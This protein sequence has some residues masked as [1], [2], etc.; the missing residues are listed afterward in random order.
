MIELN[1][2]RKKQRG[3]WRVAAIKKA[4]QVEGFGWAGV[5]RC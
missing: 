2:Y 3:S 5:A 4:L 1:R